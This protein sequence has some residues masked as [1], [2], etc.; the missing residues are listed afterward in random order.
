MSDLLY[1]Y[2]FWVGVYLGA[3]LM[4]AW[5]TRCLAQIGKIGE[6]HPVLVMLVCVVVG[7]AWP[8]TLIGGVVLDASKARM[9]K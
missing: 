2:D 3:S 7:L 4:D 8:V 9:E 5:H 6:D 1:V